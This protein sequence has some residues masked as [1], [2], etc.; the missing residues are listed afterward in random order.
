MISNG[1]ILVQGLR[2][3]KHVGF[4]VSNVGCC[5]TGLL[6][7]SVLCNPLTPTICGNVSNHVFW[8]SYHPTEK[9]YSILAEYLYQK[10]V[11]YLG[12]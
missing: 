3:L 12:V 10:L 11:P 9:A 5:G 2:C 8:D 7:V 6:E 1:T 4:E